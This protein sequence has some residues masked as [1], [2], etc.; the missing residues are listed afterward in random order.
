[1]APARFL[2]TPDRR[3]GRPVVAETRG[4]RCK[5]RRPGISSTRNRP[6][7][8]PMLV[9][10]LLLL[11]ALALLT[12]YTRNFQSTLVALSSHVDATAGAHLMPAAQ[13]LRTIGLLA[14]W[15]S[16][17]A[18]GVLFV[19]WWKAMAL[20]LGAF[21]LLVPALGALT[22]RP[23]SDHYV[24]R[25]RADLLRRIARGGRD[26]GQ[27]REVLDRLDRITSTGSR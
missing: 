21:L 8:P 23:R 3:T 9:V 13:R 4:T 19:A 26:A 16:A 10:Y 15:P 20:V 22:P 18:L 27:L 6:S 2:V 14:G 7:I 12:A 11:G 24:A 25:I 17:V 5:S 1:M